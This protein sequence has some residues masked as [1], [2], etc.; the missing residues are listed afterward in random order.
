VTQWSFYDDELGMLVVP[1]GDPHPER[2]LLQMQAYRE[3]FAEGTGASDHEALRELVLGL[4]AGTPERYLEGLLGQLHPDKQ[5]LLNR[6]FLVRF[7]GRTGTWIV[8]PA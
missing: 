2:A 3:S 5:L 4:R 8:Q 7:E 6:R 1:A